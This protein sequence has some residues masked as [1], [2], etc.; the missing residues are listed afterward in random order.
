MT[1]TTKHPATSQQAIKVSLLLGDFTRVSHTDLE[2]IPSLGE[3][4]SKIICLRLMI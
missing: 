1:P 3:T 2:I 4:F